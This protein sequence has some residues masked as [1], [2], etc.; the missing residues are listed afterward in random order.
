ML[1]SI[2]EKIVHRLR[3]NS[4]RKAPR[5]GGPRRLSIESLE[6]RKMLSVT[7]LT[8]NAIDD[9]NFAVP[10]LAANAFQVGPSSSP[11]QFAGDAGVSAN[12][13][14]FTVGNSNSPSGTQVA[15]LKN[16]ASISQNVYLDAGV[17]NLTF[18]A[19]QRVNYETQ[20]QE[21]EVLVDGAEIGLLVPPSTAYTTCQT[22]NFT[23]AAGEHTVEFLGMSPQTADST[24]FIDEVTISPVV[25]TIL[26][27]G[28]EQPAMS[29]NTL[30]TDPS[31]L[32]WQFA[33]TA[34][35]ATNGNSAEPQNAPEGTQAGF[36]Q[37]GG[38]IS[39]TAYLDA[40]SYQVSF[41]ACQGTTDQT[42]YQQIEILV[43]GTAYGTIE[44]AERLVCLLPVGRV[45]GDERS[46][47][48]R[49]AGRRRRGKRRNRFRG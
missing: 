32:P 1:R 36:V 24:A 18:L 26:D 28:F 4:R 19:A 17:Y 11:W 48:D 12:K 47:H 43:D 21:I 33:G 3:A 2:Y 27:G 20:D 25:D 46:A 30:D 42:N 44:P 13:S 5:R 35:V 29:A 31:G 15:F 39:Q 38:S 14:G 16:N 6:S 9:G 7:T 10:A 37:N 22:S 41:M 23:V 8:T 40:G 49:V 45:L 34:G